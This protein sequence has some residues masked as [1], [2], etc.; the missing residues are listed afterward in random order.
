MAPVV[1]CRLGRRRLVGAANR[2]RRYKVLQSAVDVVDV[3]QRRQAQGKGNPHE[4]RRRNGGSI[5]GRQINQ[6]G[7]INAGRSA[8]VERVTLGQAAGHFADAAE[9]DRHI[10]DGPVERRTAE[11]RCVRRDVEIAED[12]AESVGDE[13]A[14]V[15]GR[16]GQ[17]HAA[18]IGILGGESPGAVAPVD[19]LKGYAGGQQ[20]PGSRET[21]HHGQGQQPCA[22]RTKPLDLSDS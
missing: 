6:V 4:R 9:G 15:G 3:Q 7:P 10:L 1:F 2:Q 20:R 22:V 5:D 14:R 21:G 12:A 16:K 17:L 13:Q 8:E 18:P 19:L 11:R